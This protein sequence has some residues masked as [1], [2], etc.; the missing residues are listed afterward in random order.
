MPHT[1]REDYAA[2]TTTFSGIECTV[3]AS[4]HDRRRA[5]PL[6]LVRDVQG[7]GGPLPEGFSAAAPRGTLR[8]ALEA[9]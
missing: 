1:W 5:R 8:S 2:D 6:V 4:H 7:S 3:R 9:R